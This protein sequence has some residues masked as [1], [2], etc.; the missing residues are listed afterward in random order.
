[1]GRNLA[2]ASIPWGTSLRDRLG[3]GYVEALAKIAR[4]DPSAATAVAAFGD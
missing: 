4:K 2:P 3:R 1:M